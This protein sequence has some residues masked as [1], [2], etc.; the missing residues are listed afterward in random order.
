[1]ADRLLQSEPIQ[2]TKD[3]SQPSGVIYGQDPNDS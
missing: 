3:W 2:V 1:M